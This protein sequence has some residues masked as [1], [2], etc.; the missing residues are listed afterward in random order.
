MS[1]CAGPCSGSI[2][3]WNLTLHVDAIGAFDTQ[4]AGANDPSGPAERAMNRLEGLS[5]PCQTVLND[6]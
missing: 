3:R 5:G 4:G 6:D 1:D 2:P